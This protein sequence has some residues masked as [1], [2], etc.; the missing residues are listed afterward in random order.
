MVVVDE[1]GTFAISLLSG[2]IGGANALAEMIAS[3]IGARPVITTASDVGGIIA[4]DLIGR[5]FG[6]ELENDSRVT[7]VSA[8]LVNGE[9]VG[10]YQDAGERS[11]QQ[12]GSLP[13]NAHI[14][15]NPE[16]LK[17]SDCRAA[18][19]ITDHIL[20]EEHLFPEPMLV[21]R[22]KSL[23]LGIGCNRGTS[24]EVIDEAVQ[25]RMR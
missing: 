14:Y 5:E 2:H 4:V 11:W 13:V 16:A 17:G 7:A 22:P 3:R 15:E 8:A 1:G 21:Y 25:Q 24:S 6:W 12:K 23:V 10:I 20:S 19:I 18:I 9:P